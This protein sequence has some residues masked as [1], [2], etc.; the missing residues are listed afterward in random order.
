MLLAG[1][2]NPRT[3][4]LHTTSGIG[5]GVADNAVGSIVS[6][7]SRPFIKKSTDAAFSDWSLDVIVL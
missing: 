5:S 2:S 4:A 7:A 1:P 3:T 6:R